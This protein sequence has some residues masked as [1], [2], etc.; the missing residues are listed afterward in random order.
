[1]IPIVSAEVKLGTIVT[2]PWYLVVGGWVGRLV[3]RLVGQ[4]VGRS[5]GR[6]V[7]WVGGWLRVVGR[8]GRV[9]RV[10]ALSEFLSQC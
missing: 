4:L 9:G 1:M 3:G 8:V 2:S 10:E 7:G 6:M 5:V